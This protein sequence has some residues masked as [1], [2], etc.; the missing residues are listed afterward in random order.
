MYLNNKFIILIAIIIFILY[1][2]NSKNTENFDS[3]KKKLDFDLDYINR[4][5]SIIAISIPNNNTY[6]GTKNGSLG[7]IISNTNNKNSYQP[8][9]QNI[10]NEKYETVYIY[11]GKNNGVSPNNL[12]T[13]Q[14]NNVEFLATW[15]I[16]KQTCDN[17]DKTY[18]IRNV[19][20]D[21]FLGSGKISDN[22]SNNIVYLTNKESLNYDNLWDINKVGFNEYTIKNISNNLYLYSAA[23]NNKD[24]V[25]NSY[26]IPFNNNQ[27][28]SKPQ[29]NKYGEVGV[30]QNKFK[31][32]IAPLPPQNG[33][34]RETSYYL[35]SKYK[36]D[37][38]SMK[39][40]IP[41]S[42]NKKEIV[43]PWYQNSNNNS[44]CIRHLPIEYFYLQKSL[45]PVYVL[46][47][48]GL[49]PWGS[50][51]GFKNQNAKWIWYTKNAQQ[52]APAGNGKIF[53]YIYE[54]KQNVQ[55]ATINC[56]ADYQAKIY[57]NNQL[58][59]TQNG[60]WGS[61]G[62][63]WNANL[64]PGINIFSFEAINN[65]TAENPAG[66]LVTV[67]NSDLESTP[68]L[69]STGDKGWGYTYG[70]NLYTPIKNEK[71]NN[72]NN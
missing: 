66:L 4:R 24:F 72:G 9:N 63:I 17:N 65:G 54:N 15:E 55:T 40:C 12:S 22:A 1:L 69:F 70:S 39:P 11:T 68:I 35:G 44:H 67:L 31:W 56:I 14:E 38:N 7:T 71:N 52:S 61:Q 29:Y 60:G 58:V 47:N 25:T 5:K 23:E 62:G 3:K 43:Y 26:K 33:N 45:K 34:W 49:S 28:H 19:D 30:N 21:R 51:P 53:V 10:E 37:P 59:G 13:I 42:D 64:M 6:E 18:L 50:C 32:F 41:L 16:I 27:F 20:T 46:G 2:Y 48:I 8:S 36:N 57:V